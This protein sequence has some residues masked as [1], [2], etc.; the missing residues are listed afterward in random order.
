VVNGSLFTRRFAL[1][2]LANA[3]FFVGMT[4]SFVLP[5]QL[6]ALGASRAEI[7]HIVGSFGLA[8]LIAIPA[9]GALADRYGRRPF[10]LIGAAVWTL[11]ALALSRLDQLGPAFYLLRLAQGLGFSLAFV[12]TNALIV[13]LAPAGGLGRAIAIFGTTTLLSHA[14]G[15]SLG[16][17]IAR[18][19]GFA[20]MWRVAAASSVVA[21]ILFAMLGEPARVRLPGAGPA[22]GMLGL[23]VR[24][25]A[26][27]ALIAGLATAVAFGTAIHFIPVFVRQRQLASHAPFFVGYVVAAVIV[28][29]AAGGLGDRLGHRKVASAAAIAFSLSTIALS[30]V[31][32]PEQLALIALGFGAA[33][34]WGYPSMNALF[35]EGA[36]QGSRGRA[37]ALFNLSFNVGITISAF[38][39][40]EIAQRYGYSAMWLVM[41]AAAGAGAFALLLDRPRLTPPADRA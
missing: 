4:I 34:G 35:V 9:T 5:V 23:A 17:W 18:H 19:Y 12:A 8:S 10:M 13:D 40:G 26:R 33:H 25:G 36:P 28:R 30:L 3:I 41:G 31:H 20:V 24:R 21:L 29:L 22:L 16:E 39:A 1:A 2:T 15:P 32:R 38:G 37:M 11:V 6:E 7:G 14:L 27:G